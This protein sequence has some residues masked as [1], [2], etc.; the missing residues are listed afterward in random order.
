LTSTVVLSFSDPNY[1]RWFFNSGGSLRLQ[2]SKTAGSGGPQNSA[3][4][5]LCSN[6]GT[7][8]LTSTSANKTIAS[9]SV[10]GIQSIGGGGSPSVTNQGY[11]QLPQYKGS[12]QFRLGAAPGSSYT[13][14]NITVSYWTSGA[15]VYADITFT[16][17]NATGYYYYKGNVVDG[18]LSVTASAVPSITNSGF[19]ASWGTPAITVTAPA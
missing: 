5:T 15:T 6:F 11:Y 17:V 2:V 12:P 1:L 16:N 7:V 8:W 9:Q 3:W 14:S 4:Q 10:N 13:G 19:S 18:S